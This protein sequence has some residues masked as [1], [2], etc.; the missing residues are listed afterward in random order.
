MGKSWVASCLA[1]HEE[2][3]YVNSFSVYVGIL[4]VV[5]N[6]LLF[7]PIKMCTFAFKQKNDFFARFIIKFE[8]K[9]IYE[10][11]HQFMGNTMVQVPSP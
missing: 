3:K 10:W 8:T 4:Y 7:I 1:S 9:I 11:N 5:S 6:E 2:Y